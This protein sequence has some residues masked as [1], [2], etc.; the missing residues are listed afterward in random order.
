[1]GVIVPFLVSRMFRSMPFLRGGYSVGMPGPVPGFDG[2]S[3][4]SFRPEVIVAWWP[5]PTTFRPIPFSRGGYSVGMSGP[6]PG[7]GGQPPRSFR[8]EVCQFLVNV[9]VKVNVVLVW[10][11]RRRRG[12]GRA[13][14][15]A[16]ATFFLRGI[17]RWWR[18]WWGR[19]RALKLVAPIWAAE[20]KAL[21]KPVCCQL[22]VTTGGLMLANVGGSCCLGCLGCSSQSLSLLL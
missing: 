15:G 21:Y 7:L 11:V 17:G 13:V 5:G 10:W 20:V 3:P 16:M 12:G 1:M 8:P 22:R 6:V 14:P 2:P 19:E 18:C 9:V 4:R